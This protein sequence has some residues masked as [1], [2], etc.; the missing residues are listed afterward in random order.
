MACPMYKDFTRECIKELGGMPENTLP[1][2]S[3]SRYIECPFYIALNNLGFACEFLKQCPA[4]E[5]FK[6]DNFEEFV[7]IAN[8]YCLSKENCHD[9]ERYKIRKSG[10]MPPKKL[11][12]NG[13]F[14]EEE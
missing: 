13:T 12:P 9:C 14:V 5:H 10:N 1:F 3:T 11:L 8:D 6:H 2:C 7:K 4:Y